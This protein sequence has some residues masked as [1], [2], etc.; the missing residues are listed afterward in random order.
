MQIAGNT[1]GQKSATPSLVLV[2]LNNVISEKHEDEDVNLFGTKMV[3]IIGKLRT[4]NIR[5]SLS[6]S[7]SVTAE[8][9]DFLKNLGVPLTSTNVALYKNL[10]NK[11]QRIGRENVRSLILKIASRTHAR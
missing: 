3:H 6:I 8:D 1:S 10:T 9:K 7:A 4:M 11:V 5:T 2:K